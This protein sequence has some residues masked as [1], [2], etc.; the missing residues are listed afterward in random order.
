MDVVTQYIYSISKETNDILKQMAEEDHVS[1]TT[2]IE[3]AISGWYRF[4]HGYAHLATSD[5]YIIDREIRNLQD[6]LKESKRR[7]SVQLSINGEMEKIRKSLDG[8]IREQQEGM[9][10]VR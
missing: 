10:N 1:I 3:N 5:P 7:A 9:K 8:S 4:R 2:E 6:E